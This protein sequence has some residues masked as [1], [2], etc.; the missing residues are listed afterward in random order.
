MK[1]RELV[2]AIA[3]CSGILPAPLRLQLDQR[4]DVVPIDVRASISHPSIGLKVE[5]LDEAVD[6]LAADRELSGDLIDRSR[7]HKPEDTKSKSR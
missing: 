3:G 4:A 6:R 2:S 5:A 7:I 1:V